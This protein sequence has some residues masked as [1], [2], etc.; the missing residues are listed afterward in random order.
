MLWPLGEMGL[1]KIIQSLMWCSKQVSWSKITRPTSAYNQPQWEVKVENKAFEDHVDSGR[2]GDDWS[3][4][5]N[6]SFASACIFH[7][8]T[9][10]HIHVKYFPCCMFYSFNV[11]W[12]L[13]SMWNASAIPEKFWSNVAGMSEI[14]P[15]MQGAV[16][17][18]EDLQ[19]TLLKMQRAAIPSEDLQHP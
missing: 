17:L 7:A 15:K 18:S 9:H 5:S 13:L 2:R 16:V 12:F 4:L 14:L 19:Q 8:C 10:A 3:S 1:L 6:S 11:V